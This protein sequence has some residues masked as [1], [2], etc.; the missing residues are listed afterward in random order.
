MTADHES[1]LLPWALA[2]VGGVVS[3]LLTGLVSLFRL[4]EQENAKNIAELKEKVCVI[5]AKA[6]KC[7]E[8]RSELRTNYAVLQHEFDALKLRIQ[9]ID[10][11]GTQ[12]SHRKDL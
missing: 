8:D 5:E 10:V 4:R 3:A 7:E 6:D 9:A 1:G 12:Y 11:E 2:G